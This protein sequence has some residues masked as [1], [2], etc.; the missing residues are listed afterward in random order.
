MA[1]WLMLGIALLGAGPAMGQVPPALLAGGCQ[2]CHGAAGEGVG[3]IP[4]IHNTRTRDDF[5]A[6][7]QAFRTNAVPNTIMGRIARGYTEAE[8]Q[9]LAAHFGRPQ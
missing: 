1:R 5:A 8:I 6:T 4:A 7:M 2:G 9:A 3:G